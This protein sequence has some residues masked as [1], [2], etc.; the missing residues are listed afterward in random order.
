L[1]LPNHDILVKRCGICWKDKGIFQSQ[2]VQ[3][4]ETVS[5]ILAPSN[6]SA[7]FDK[8]VVEHH[9]AFQKLIKVPIPT[10]Q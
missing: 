8:E 2:S 6:N 4:W 5:G 9:L 3:N 1:F 10:V 7:I